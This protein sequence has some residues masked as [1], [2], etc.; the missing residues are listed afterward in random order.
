LNQE[1]GK[2]EEKQDSPE[3]K[4]KK[5]FKFENLNFRG[6]IIMIK[7]KRFDK[8]NEIKLKKLNEINLI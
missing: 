7:N 4:K 1:T 8:K 3:V 2:Y 5:I 6:R